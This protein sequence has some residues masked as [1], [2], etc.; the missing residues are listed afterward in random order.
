M[1]TNDI[2]SAPVVAAHTSRLRA[3]LPRQIGDGNRLAAAGSRDR[4]GTVHDAQSR[5]PQLE[6]VPDRG[7]CQLHIAL[8]GAAGIDHQAETRRAEPELAGRPALGI[9]ADPQLAGA[10]PARGAKRAPDDPHRA[11]PAAVTE[12]QTEHR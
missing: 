3:E 5:D 11:T 10:V 1:A 2:R 4:H 8:A 12:R 6:H 7:F 9:S